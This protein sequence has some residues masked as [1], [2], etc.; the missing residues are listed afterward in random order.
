MA[1]N[2]RKKQEIIHN[3]VIVRTKYLGCAKTGQ[4]K[5]VYFVQKNGNPVYGGPK[6]ELYA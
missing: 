3:F 6:N 2:I 4:K 5:I 1:M